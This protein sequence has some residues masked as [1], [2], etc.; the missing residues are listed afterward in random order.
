MSWTALSNEDTGGTTAD[1]MAISTYNVYIKPYKDP[2]FSNNTSR[3]TLVCSQCTS[4]YTVPY[5]S[6]GMLYDF[7]ISATNI[8]GESQMRS[9]SPMMAG[10]SSNFSRKTS[11]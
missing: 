10:I 2:K 8:I 7:A 11:C 1:P 3:Y 9:V 4:S 5:L 6:S